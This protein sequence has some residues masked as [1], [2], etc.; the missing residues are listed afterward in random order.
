MR[1]NLVKR[2]WL[3]GLQSASGLERVGDYYYLIGDDSPTLVC[4]DLQFNIVGTTRLFE[5]SV[6]KGERIAKLAKPDLE[7]MCCVEWNR[8]RELICFGSGSKSPA[9]D[10]CFRV[11]VTD[12]ASPRNV[13]AVV[14]TGLYDSLRANP[15]I[16]STQTLNLEAAAATGD[17]IL[18][19]QRG[20]ISGCNAVIEFG[21]NEFMQYLDAPK[22]FPPAAR[23]AQY[24]L[25][26]IQARH[27][28][29]SAALTWDDTIL[30]SASVEDTDNE[31][32]DGA[33]LGSFLGMIR[34][35]QLQWVLVVEQNGHMAP[36][37][38]EGITLLT[39]RE[40]YLQIAAVTDNDEGTSELL[41]IEIQ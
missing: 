30:F 31:I 24:V 33:T 20:N 40:G 19:F 28:G 34:E 15:G 6:G 39:A 3:K 21:L 25:P 37:K 9:R 36:V 16:V 35:K 23:V 32:D 10:V 13:R 38:I 11:D 5:A 7:A 29:F 8:R 22:S 1:A 41:E 17:T 18:L 12:P 2:R 4:L 26:Q 14:L 27:A